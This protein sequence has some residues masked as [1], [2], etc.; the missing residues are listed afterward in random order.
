M[1]LTLADV[2]RW[3]PDD[4]H[5]VFQA[6]ISRAEGTRGTANGLGDVMKAVP[7]EG[8][9]HDAATQS[10]NQIRGD[11]TAHADECEAV[12]RAASAAEAEVRAI[13]ADWDA[14]Q[15]DARTSGI[16]IDAQNGTLIY[17]EPSDRVARQQ[18]DAKAADIERRIRELI[19]RA[20]AADKD[21][22]GAI[23]TAAGEESVQALDEQLAKHGVE[24][25]EQ[26]EKDVHSALAGDQQAAGRVAKV[27]N[28]IT[29]DQRDGK[30]L[31][32]PQQASVLSQMQAQENGMSADALQTA[33]QRLGD[34]KGIIGDCWQLMSNPNVKF[35]QT[36]LKVGATED[37][38]TRVTG[39][40]GLLPVSVQSTLGMDAVKS[41]AASDQTKVATQNAQD[42][43]KI[44]GIVHDGSPMFQQG[45]RG[46]ELDKGMMQW[47]GDVLHHPVR[48]HLAI[49]GFQPDDSGAQYNT[50]RLASDNAMADVF[51][52]AGRDHTAVHDQMTSPGGQ[53]FL[54]DVHMHDWTDSGRNTPSMHS[55][56]DWIGADAGAGGPTRQ[57][58]GEAAQALATCLSNNHNQLLKVPQ[59]LGMTASIGE[60]NPE[61]VR[62][63]ETALAPFQRA[64]IG[65]LTGTQGFHVG[66]GG[67]GNPGAGDFSAARN[68]FAVIDSDPDAAQRFNAAADG[69]ILNYEHDFA[70]QAAGTPDRAHSLDYLALRQASSMLGVVDA[71]AATEAAAR[72]AGEAGFYNLKKA[73][74]DYLLSKGVNAVPGLSEVPGLD[75]AKET[76][77]QGLIGETG[78]HHSA[79]PNVAVPSFQQGMDTAAY[80]VAMMFNPQVAGVPQEL[81][82]FF[83]PQTGQLLPPDRVEPGSVE[84]YSSALQT[85]LSGLDINRFESQF[86]IYYSEGAGVSTQSTDKTPFSR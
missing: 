25:P 11:L 43:S 5:A 64:M 22:A 55:L 54:T 12:G 60:L 2:E 49:P 7:W 61:L 82:Q 18:M 73:G 41:A 17:V 84:A 31:L 77:E 79:D 13:K 24:T 44:A 3:N 4:I 15:A 62:A 56:F 76:L 42:M 46:T 81:S 6:C 67:L 78:A 45:A 80:R 32:T 27:I 8:Q 35:S 16:T 59:G 29:A 70:E 57:R 72:G 36:P 28:S 58:A 51:N 39:S 40:R 9:A 52:S 75:L 74:L 47:S 83:D 48:Q 33:E 30:V 14:I 38:N 69:N 23:N 66:P 50:Y 10:N 65:D 71:G 86:N 68:V 21:L 34:N 19:T 20:N 85:Y 1:G 37:P 53:D 26:A 63:D